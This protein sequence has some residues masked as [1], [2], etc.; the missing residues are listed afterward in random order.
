MLVLGLLAGSFLLDR[1]GLFRAGGAFCHGD[2]SVD[3]ALFSLVGSISSELF[4]GIWAVG[5]HRV[6]PVAVRWTR[7]D[8][9]LTARLLLVGGNDVPLLTFPFG[10]L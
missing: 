6:F 8:E 10:K 2:F 5:A 3:Q 4:V 9:I 7:F 1:P